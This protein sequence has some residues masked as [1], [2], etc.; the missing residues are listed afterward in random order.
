MKKIYLAPTVEIVEI[1]VETQL[2]AASNGTMPDFLMNDD[3]TANG[4]ESLSREHS[5]VWDFDE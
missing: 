4:D 5:S 2:M 1:N 3:E